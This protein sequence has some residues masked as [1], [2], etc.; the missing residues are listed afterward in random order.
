MSVRSRRARVDAGDARHDPEP[1]PE[2]RAR[3]RAWR[4]RPTTSASPGTRTGG[5]VQ[6]FGNV[7]AGV[8]G[9]RFEDAIAAVQ[10]RRAASQ[11]DTELD[12]RRAARA[13]GTFK[14]VYQEH[15]GESSPG[16]ARAAAARRSARCSTPGRGERAVSYRRIN[17]IPDDWGTA[18]NV[19]QMVFGNK[20]DTLRPPA[21]PSAATRSPARPS[22]AATS[23]STRR[24]RTSSP[25]SAPR[26]TSPS[27]PR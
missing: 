23:W 15:T 5:F 25:A 17:R 21:S 20:G 22:R 7:V 3:C 18:V 13:D 4:G 9:E 11:L 1:R 27:W 14:D 12:G 6:M 16:S 10:A 8:P 2:R 19:Q 24:A 26:A